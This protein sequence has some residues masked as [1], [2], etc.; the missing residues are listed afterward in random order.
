MHCSELLEEIEELRSEM[1]SLF[2]SDAV[3]ASLL[4]IS[5]QLDDLI[6]RYYRRVA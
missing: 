4:D 5:Q 1:Y 6:V 3:C 2:S